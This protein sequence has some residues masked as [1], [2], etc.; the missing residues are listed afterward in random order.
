MKIRGFTCNSGKQLD[1]H[2]TNAF[3]MTRITWNLP[4]PSDPSPLPPILTMPQLPVGAAT[5]AV[6]GTF[7][8]VFLDSILV[9]SPPFIDMALKRTHDALY[10]L[11]AGDCNHTTL[12]LFQQV[13][14]VSETT[15]P[16]TFPLLTSVNVGIVIPRFSSYL[17]YF[18]PF[19][20]SRVGLCIPITFT[21]GPCWNLV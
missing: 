14:K 10:F 16:P 17:F 13:Q 2:H 15:T 3:K 11:V 12:Y 6:G 18:A 9:C 19:L 8:G 20:F 21:G 1:T 4:H 5:P 7:L